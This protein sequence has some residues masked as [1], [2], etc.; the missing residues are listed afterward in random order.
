MMACG[1]SIP[2]G[3][4]KLGAVLGHAIRFVV[5]KAVG[6][7]LDEA[8]LGSVV[9]LAHFKVKQ[10]DEVLILDWPTGGSGPTIPLPV[11]EPFVDRLEAV[12]AVGE[13][14]E[15]TVIVTKA[16]NSL[17]HGGELGAIIALN[18]AGQATG[19]VEML[20]VVVVPPYAPTRSGIGCAVSEAGAVH[21]TNDCLVW[22]VGDRHCYD[23]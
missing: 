20:E 4:S 23:S 22:I 2:V 7:S 1:E 14:D 9:T 8:E 16:L 3:S 12:R 10:R 5:A 6:V 21:E 11:G 13:D 15:L 19:L 18:V 17:N